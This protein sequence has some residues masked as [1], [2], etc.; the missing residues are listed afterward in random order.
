MESLESQIVEKPLNLSQGVLA[1]VAEPTIDEVMA[2]E[3]LP[4]LAKSMCFIKVKNQMPVI[5]VLTILRGRSL[6]S[7]DRY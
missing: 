5:P 4:N 7:G 2:G 1:A 6:M 3:F